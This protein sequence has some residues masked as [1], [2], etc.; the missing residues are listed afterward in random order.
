MDI[1]E[2]FNSL[3]NLKDDKRKATM[4]YL[5]G[6]IDCDAYIQRMSEIDRAANK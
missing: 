5:S 1:F 2:L 3:D 6:K 4:D